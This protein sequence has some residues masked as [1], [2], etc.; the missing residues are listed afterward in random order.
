MKKLYVG[1]MVVLFVALTTTVFAFGPKSGF[2]K[3]VNCPYGPI[4]YGGP[5]LNPGFGPGV[6]AGLG[7]TKEQSEKMWQAREAFRKETENLRYELFQKRAELNKLYA[8]PNADETTIR[9]KQNEV[10]SLRQNLQDKMAQF[11]L[12]QRKI[13]TPEQLKKLN[14]LQAGGRGPGFRRCTPCEGESNCIPGKGRLY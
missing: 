9:A 6:A 3:G 12:E 13:L 1:I 10:N 11:R 8:D 7:L 4:Q 14:E 2:G 5:G